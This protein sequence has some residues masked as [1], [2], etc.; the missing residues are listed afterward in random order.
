LRRRVV[1]GQLKTWRSRQTHRTLSRADVE[2]LALRTYAYRKHIGDP[3]SYW[4][5]GQRAADILGVNMARVRQLAYAELI[6]AERH[7]DGTFMY[8]RDQLMT[9]ANAR[10]ARWH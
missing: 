8:R 9:V 6:P 4:V 7:A 3:G 2:A 1:S 5:T 10:E